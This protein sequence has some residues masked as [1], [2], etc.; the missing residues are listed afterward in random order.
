M[1]L[2]VPSDP[3]TDALQRVNLMGP[4]LLA[5]RSRLGLTATQQADRIGISATSLNGII[6]GTANSSKTTITAV[7]RW[8]AANR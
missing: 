8:L 3:W 7:L 2:L 1:P 5:A 4:D 6:A